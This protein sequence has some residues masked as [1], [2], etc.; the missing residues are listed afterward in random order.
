[1][2][3][4][5]KAQ[6]VPAGLFVSE[7]I[8]AFFSVIPTWVLGFLIGFT[9]FWLVWSI[10]FDSQLVKRHPFLRDWF[11]FLDPLGESLSDTELHSRYIDG[12]VFKLTELAVDGE[13]CDRTFENCVIHGPAVVAPS[14]YTSQFDCEYVANDDPLQLYWVLDFQPDVTPLS[15]LPQGALITRK[16]TFKKCRFVGIGWVTTKDDAEKKAASLRRPK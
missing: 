16:C 11:P 14:D 8:I 12:K 5:M 7:V 15:K 4:K 2:L 1:M 13:V 6:A 9:V 3:K 10:F